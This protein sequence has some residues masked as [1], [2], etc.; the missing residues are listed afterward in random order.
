MDVL[1]VCQEAVSKGSISNELA[2]KLNLFRWPRRLTAVEMAT[3][4]FVMRRIEAGK[5]QVKAE[6]V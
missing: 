4:D 1:N 3:I 5:I 6:S 2:E